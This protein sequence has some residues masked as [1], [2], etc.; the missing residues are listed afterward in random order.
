MR[1]AAHVLLCFGLLLPSLPARSS[2]ATAAARPAPGVAAAPKK[3]ALLVGVSKYERGTPGDEWWD[4]NTG[5][6]VEAMRQV[7]TVKFQF[8]EDE[9]KVLG[10]PQETTR[11]SI[12][13]AFR[14]FLI[15][16]ARPGDIIY[17]HYSGHGGQVPD[18]DGPGNPFVGDELDGL[19]ESLIPSDYVSKKDG[20]NSLR[21]DEISILLGELK[22]KRPASVTLSFDSCF[23]GT[24]TRGGRHKAR[25]QQW[26]GPPPP[27]KTRGPEEGP[28][29]LLQLGEA[30]ANG[31]VLMTATRND[32]VATET[33]D[34]NG[35]AM[36]P[37][38]YTLARALSGA[39]PQTTYRDIFER[40]N[41]QI[42]RLGLAQNPQLEGDVDQVVLSGAA[43]PP[44]PYIPVS[45]DRVGN[46]T[47]QAGELQGMTLGS[48]FALFPAGTK[49]FKDAEPKAEAEIVKLGLGSAVLRLAD[50]STAKG[51][52]P[53]EL[54]AARAVER[55]HRYGDSRLKV[56][57]R[58]LENAAR[59]RELAERVR[60]LPLVNG[61]A[62]AAERWDV[63]ACPVKC[64]DQRP[65]PGGSGADDPESIVLQRQ[66]G[67]VLAV[68]PGGNDQLP[69]IRD[70]LEGEARW[71][72]LN[73]LGNEN[74]D[75][76]IRIDLRV[77]PVEVERGGGWLKWA[78]DKEIRTADG[79]QLELTE[80]D[81]VNI[82]LK[83]SGTK[84][85]YVT[86]LNL[87]NDGVIGPIWPH[88]DVASA[89]QENKIPADK[90]WHRLAKDTY[91]FRIEKPYGREVYKAI[92]TGEPADFSPLL[93][94]K[95]LARGADDPAL[96]KLAQT[97]LGQLL[98]SI[99][100]GT[101]SAQASVNP[102]DWASAVAIFV[103]K[104]RR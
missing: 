13:A 75:S 26:A 87:Q 31:Y 1:R 71:R 28:G 62:E 40:V 25:G 68:V 63:L 46:V 52:K 21:D 66:D 61:G 78:R 74:P 44:Q 81:Y 14:S 90:Q 83:N 41:E 16:P 5:P 48:R 2:P 34:E 8:K 70:A 69:K 17:F 4:L 47:L 102:A 24:I 88:P 32:Q 33:E 57:L 29:G 67:S 93:D 84:D 85:A 51:V 27:V 7:L 56:N 18:A 65:A 39:G 45:V 77:V 98:T 11:R 96:R 91:I 103:V 101:R 92:A 97:P 3:R 30:V 76:Q 9:I 79:G 35:R 23:S 6:D 42:S 59:G 73:A 50:E 12:V 22:R 10:T 95:F 80:G 49:E 72:F 104:E 64:S 99:T 20:S 58:R 36:G 19:D 53:Q 43:L 38:S 82:E 15:E 37:L 54:Q 94:R 86:V 55:S 60:S 89:M 100:T